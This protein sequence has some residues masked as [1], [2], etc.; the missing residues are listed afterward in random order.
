MQCIAE[1]I[2]HSDPT[3]NMLIQCLSD[4][5]T[6]TECICVFL[7]A[8]Q[9]TAKSTAF[10]LQLDLITLRTCDLRKWMT[11]RLYETRARWKGFPFHTAQR[12][13]GTRIRNLIATHYKWSLQKAWEEAQIST[14]HGAFFRN[15]PSMA[16][17]SKYSFSAKQSHESR[18]NLNKE[19]T[20]VTIRW[21][22]CQLAMQS[23]AKLCL[24]KAMGRLTSAVIGRFLYKQVK[25]HD[26]KCWPSQ[27]AN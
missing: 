23:P 6:I 25:S 20:E 2:V 5:A 10:L 17:K 19:W 21:Y 24:D 13:D 14:L 11:L 22:M 9:E 1:S 3:Q 12:R 8:I 15:Q 4:G 7:R 26:P 16:R 18:D 27:S